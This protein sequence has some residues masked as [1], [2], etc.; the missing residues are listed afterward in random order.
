MKGRQYTR[1]EGEYKGLDGMMPVVKD[2]RES[3]VRRR[4]AE[5]GR[6]GPREWC[7]IRGDVSGDEYRA[8][9]PHNSPL[10]APNYCLLSNNP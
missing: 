9:H 4:P 1:A 5:G 3:M 10:Q 6:E 8:W 2:Q 7:A